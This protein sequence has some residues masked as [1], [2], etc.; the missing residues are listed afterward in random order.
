MA[1][2][3]NSRCWVEV[4][5]DDAQCSFVLRGVRKSIEILHATQLMLM[6]S[7]WLSLH[8]LVRY[9]VAAYWS[10]IAMYICSSAIYHILCTCSDLNSHYIPNPLYTIVK[11]NLLEMGVNIVNI[12]LT[13]ITY[14]KVARFIHRLIAIRWFNAQKSSLSRVVYKNWLFVANN[15]QHSL[16]YCLNLPRNL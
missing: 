15:I 2:R 8:G 14:S 10:F 16:Q 6:S 3:L 11:M 1:S 4:E 7:S 12:V 13:L 5:P 9:V